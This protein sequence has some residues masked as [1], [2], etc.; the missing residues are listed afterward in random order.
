MQYMKRVAVIG[1]GPGAFFTIKYLL[2]RSPLGQFKIDMFEKL[3]APFGLVRFGVAPDHADVKEVSNEFRELLRDSSANV[4]LFTSKTFSGGGSL[5]ELKERYDAVLI[6][7]GAQESRRL[8]MSNLPGNT[9]SAQDFVLWYNGHPEKQD[10]RLPEAPR[11]VSIVGHG[12]VA[13][14]VARMLCKSEK[15]L[16][17]L[18]ESGLLSRTAHEWLLRRQLLGGKKTVSVIGRR[19][20]LDAAFTNKEL[21][22]LTAMADAACVVK[23]SE[24]EGSLADLKAR[25]VSDRGKSR[26]IS[27]L[28][29]CISNQSGAVSNRI[30]LR[31]FCKPLQY[32][33][34][35]AEAIQVKR[36]DAS[37]ETIPTDM[38]IESIGFRVKNE[39]GLAMNEKTGGFA[40]DGNGRVLG[41]PG[42][43]VAGW[44][45]RGP[46]GVI[47]ANIPCSMET[48]EAMASDLSGGLNAATKAPDADYPNRYFP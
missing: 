48:A 11:N 40:H 13:L 18:A 38:G 25:T 10:V 33:G 12:N 15:E 31:F 6:S 7:T 41:W 43:Y 32:I 4:R 45:K 20:Y 35:P 17:P 23:E 2:K 27:I 44:A 30:F 21:R 34:Y 1:S 9:L 26:G 3:A 8:S 28:S 24:L 5:Q 36:P 16:R 42:V 46:R 47:A 37:E 22:E 14:D 39:W 29:K 19:G